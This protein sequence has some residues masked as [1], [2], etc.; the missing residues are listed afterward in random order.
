MLSLV[1]PHHI[2]NIVESLNVPIH[3]DLFHSLND[4]GKNST[5]HH[6]MASFMFFDSV[7]IYEHSATKTIPIKIENHNKYNDWNVLNN[8]NTDIYV[9][10]KTSCALFNLRNTCDICVQQ[11]LYFIFTYSLLAIYLEPMIEIHYILCNKH[12]VDYLF[13]ILHSVYLS[14]RKTAPAWLH[15]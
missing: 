13:T 3:V 1:C 9:L 14:S 10:Y 2:I 7:F 11:R 15:L 5:S 12:I 8:P 4:T 6:I